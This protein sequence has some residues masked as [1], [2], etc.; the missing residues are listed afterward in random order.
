MDYVNILSHKEW[1]T[2]PDQDLTLQRASLQSRFLF[3]VEFHQF[4]NGHINLHGKLL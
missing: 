4:S 3:F 1:L 2:Q